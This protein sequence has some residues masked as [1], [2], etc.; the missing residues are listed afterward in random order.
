MDNI[1]PDKVIDMSNM[2][3]EAVANVEVEE[4]PQKVMV[5][6]YVYKKTTTNIQEDITD[7]NKMTIDIVMNYDQVTQLRKMCI[8]F[9]RHVNDEKRRL[10]KEAKNNESTTQN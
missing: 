1:T 9:M 6:Q 7:P 5:F 3:T 2:G 10:E 4:I 8:D